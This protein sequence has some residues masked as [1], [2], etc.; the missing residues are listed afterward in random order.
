MAKQKVLVFK[1]KEQALIEERELP[2]IREGEAAV[3]SLYSMVS[4]GTELAL[5][6]ETHIGFSDPDIGWCNYPLDIGYATAGVVE[7]SRIDGLRTGSTIIHYGPHADRVVITREDPVWAEVPEDLPAAASCFGR[8]AQI[9]YSS[10]AAALRSPRRVLVYGAGIVG[11]LA[12]QWFRELGADTTIVDL[13]EKRL[14]IAS[15]CGIDKTAQPEQL[16]AIER[17][18]TIVEATGVADVVSD[19]LARVA[20]R[21]QVILLGSIRKPITINA[22]K[23][24]HRKAVLL[25]GAHETVLGSARRE[26]LQRALS[27]L[28]DGALITEPI[29][30]TRIPAQE[31]PDLY[32]SMAAAP[33]ENFG[34]LAEWG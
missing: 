10:V 24:I 15:A 23:L 29:V 13:S 31:L 7:E 18:D 33:D 19:A 5:Y 3:R 8:F 21:G 25:S 14:E 4:P 2:E 1:G 6:R 22:Y 28:R 30:T 16:A 27:A 26:V 9:A 12:A 20:T 34:V 17:V 32:K 11:N